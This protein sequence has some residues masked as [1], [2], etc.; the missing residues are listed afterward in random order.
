MSKDEIKIMV[1]K[2]AIPIGLLLTF[3]LMLWRLFMVAEEAHTA[4]K[5]SGK[6]ESKL[7][8]HAEILSEHRAVL[9][10]MT[11]NQKRILEQLDRIER[12]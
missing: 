4:E 5:R 7:E 11:E 3:G 10:G 6:N 1:G 9:S 8:V 12:K 2:T